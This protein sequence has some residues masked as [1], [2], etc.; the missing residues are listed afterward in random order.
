M[1]EYAAAIGMTMDTINCPSCRNDIGASAI[2]H[3]LSNPMH[4]E[5]V[6]AH[7]GKG[8]W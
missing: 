6:V 8:R 4:D 1:D 2:L 7:D 5:T 3:L